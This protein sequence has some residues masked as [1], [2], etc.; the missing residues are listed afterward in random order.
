M[1]F[2]FIRILIQMKAKRY[3]CT[4]SSLGERRHQVR[5]LINITVWHNRNAVRKSAGVASWKPPL[6]HL[7]ISPTFGR[8]IEPK[9]LKRRVRG[10]QESSWRRGTFEQQLLAG[11]GTCPCR[12]EHACQGGRQVKLRSA[13]RSRTSHSRRLML[14]RVLE[15]AC[16]KTYERGLIDSWNWKKKIN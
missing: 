10:E 16:H 9:H 13:N 6:A 2:R 5:S 4:M 11:V 12:A 8:A 3:T 7:K 1:I 15:G 14:K